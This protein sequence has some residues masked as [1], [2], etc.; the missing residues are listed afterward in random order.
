M[1][2]IKE[3]FEI[4]SK[5]GCCPQYVNTDGNY[6]SRDIYFKADGI[7]CYINWWS[8]IAYLSIGGRF[9]SHIWFHSLEVDRCWPSYVEG[10]KFIYNNESIVY[11]STIKLDWQYEALEG[12]N[13]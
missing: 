2:D 5:V 12:V 11:L 9:V 7:P 4:L 1:Q 3:M 8:N 6:F 10:I 13:K